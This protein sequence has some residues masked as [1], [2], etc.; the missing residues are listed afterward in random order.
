[1]VKNF[2]GQYFSVILGFHFLK[3]W[4]PYL[5]VKK[6][7]K[8]DFKL[9]DNLR[10]VI[11]CS[12]FS[13]GQ[14]VVPNSLPNWIRIFK[15][16]I[17][18]KTSQYDQWFSLENASHIICI[19]DEKCSNGPYDFSCIERMKNLETIQFEI[20]WNWS[21]ES[22]EISQILPMLTRLKACSKVLSL[23]LNCWSYPRGMYYISWNWILLFF[24]NE[25]TFY[26]SVIDYSLLVCLS[27]YQFSQ[28]SNFLTWVLSSDHL[29]V[30]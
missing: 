26:F 29:R 10:K 2:T 13:T 24:E 3:V 30:L 22:D 14:L 1:M 25:I 4:H 16:S 23:I 11:I 27:Q 7:K 9:C 5:Q 21:E 6:M 12:N 8:L 15:I 28:L 19:F 18:P 17:N 20:S